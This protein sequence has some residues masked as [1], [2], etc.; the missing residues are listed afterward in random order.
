MKKTKKKTSIAGTKSKKIVFS[1]RHA[2]VL[3][4]L[5]LTVIVKKVID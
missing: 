2:S 1:K 5:L 3:K 4:D